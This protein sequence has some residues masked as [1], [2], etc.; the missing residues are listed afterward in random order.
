MHIKGPMSNGQKYAGNG[1]DNEI[2][3]FTRGGRKVE[4]PKNKKGRREFNATS[5]SCLTLY[6]FCYLLLPMGGVTPKKL[7]TQQFGNMCP[8][9]R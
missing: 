9:N 6:T 3:L 4:G 2:R 8:K 5:P 1:V 7:P